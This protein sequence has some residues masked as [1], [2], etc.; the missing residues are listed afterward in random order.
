LLRQIAPLLDDKN[1]FMDERVEA[2]AS[3]VV[4]ISE[5][6]ERKN[7]YMN[8][9]PNNFQRCCRSDTIFGNMMTLTRLMGSNMQRQA[10]PLLHPQHLLL[11]PVWNWK[12]PEISDRF[13]LLISR[14]RHFSYQSEL[15]LPERM[16]KKILTFYEFVPAPISGTCI[17]QLPIYRGTAW[18][19]DRYWLNS[20]IFRAGRL[21]SPVRT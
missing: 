9:S 6:P 15:L 18:K 10:S 12:P 7:E 4:Y 20:S 17:N 14:H 21:S 11:P 16:A 5:I 19:K 8:V 2:R 1:Q 13:W 3:A